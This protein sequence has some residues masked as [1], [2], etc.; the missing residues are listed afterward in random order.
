M[1]D[2]NRNIYLINI[3]IHLQNL[4]KF[5][6]F[7]LKILRR[8]KILLPI[9]GH[10]FI[11]NLYKITGKHPNDTDLVNIYAFIKFGQILSICSKDTERKRN[12]DMNQGP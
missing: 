4:V 7:V 8:N 1:E 5:Y 9:K 11:T 10:N 12:S 3:C 6:P 2:S